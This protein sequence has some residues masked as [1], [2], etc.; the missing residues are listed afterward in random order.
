VR[1]VLRIAAGL[2]LGAILLTGCS[3]PPAPSAEP[4]TEQGSEQSPQEFPDVLEV[5]V[6]RAE[7][8]TFSF[9]VTMSSPYDTPERYAD[10]WRILGPDEEVLGEMTLDHDHAAEQPF[11]RSQTGV[12][13]PD[14]IT[15][16]VVEGRDLENGYGGGTKTVNLPTA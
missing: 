10:G 7:D 6:E 4:A 2:V 9:D 15:S 12:E 11:T 16:V 13:V 14:G 5:A 1:F 8:G 3:D